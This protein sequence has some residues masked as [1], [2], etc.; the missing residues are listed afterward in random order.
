MDIA[1]QIQTEDAI[2]RLMSPME[3][4]AATFN[5]TDLPDDIKFAWF[6]CGDIPES[7]WDAMASGVEVVGFRLSAF[8]AP[9]QTGYACFTL[10]IRQSQVRFLLPLG[11]ERVAWFLKDAS[12]C[13]IHLSL[14]RNNGDRALVRKFGVEPADVMPVLDIAQRCRDLRGAELITDFALAL[15]AICRKSTIPSV[16]DGVPVNEAH[17]IV[18]SPQ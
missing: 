15:G 8:T 14:S 17:A 6:L 18:V 11:S 16:F 1:E 12:L 7:F 5:R 9:V 2:G 3:V 4:Y 13:G 10:Q